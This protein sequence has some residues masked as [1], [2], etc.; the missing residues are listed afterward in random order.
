MATLEAALFESGRP[1]LLAPPTPLGTLGE[2]I[3]IAWNGTTEAARTD[4]FALPL[5]RPARAVTVVTLAS[6]QVPEPDGERLAHYT[7]PNGRVDQVRRCDSVPR[8]ARL[9]DKRRT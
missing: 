1:V 5:L 9:R 2:N 8:T 6:G 7:R 4:A 3:L